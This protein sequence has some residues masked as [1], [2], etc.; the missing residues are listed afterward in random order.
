DLLP[1]GQEAYVIRAG[2]GDRRAWPDTINAYSARGVNTGRQYFAVTTL[3]SKQPYIIRHFHQQHTEHFF[4][5]A[6]R[7]W[8]WDDGAGLLLT[9]GAG[10]AAPAGAIHSFALDAHRARML[11][12]LTTDV[13]EPLFDGPGQQRPD[14]RQADG[15]LDP[16]SVPAPMQAN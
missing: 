15:L 12:I 13:F 10:L 16:M 5:R 2:E 6:G 7:A 4:C 14:R 1:D 3:A 11:G 8:L 9:A